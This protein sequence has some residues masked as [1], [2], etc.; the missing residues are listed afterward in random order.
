MPQSAS[1]HN[2]WRSALQPADDPTFCLRQSVTR[3]ILWVSRLQTTTNPWLQRIRGWLYN[4]AHL[5]AIPALHQLLNT[6][7]WAWD[8]RN[9]TLH[10]IDVAG[11][12]RTIRLGWDGPKVLHNWLQ[13][14]WQQQLFAAEQRVWRPRYRNDN[15]K[16]MGLRLPAPPAR[17]LPIMTAR[18]AF[19]A[20]PPSFS[21]SWSAQRQVY[22]A[23]GTSVWHSSKRHNTQQPKC[24]CNADEPS[25]PHLLWGVSQFTRR[26]GFVGASRS[27]QHL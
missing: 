21:G 17:R 12:L 22:M 26:S 5:Q 7:H 9:L 2:L 20:A 8:L 11:R 1:R 16:A 24:L 6:L 25:M 10:T 27:N 3:F 23:T 15:T 19:A 13:L 4:P 18:Q 14:H